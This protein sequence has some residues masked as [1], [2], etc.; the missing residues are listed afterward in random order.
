MH[1]HTDRE[2]CLLITAQILGMIQVKPPNKIQVKS[3]FFNPRGLAT[4]L[5]WTLTSRRSPTQFRDHI[6]VYC[7]LKYSHGFMLPREICLYYPM[8]MNNANVNC[9]VCA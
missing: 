1:A 6:R 4:S 3:P 8:T 7:Q 9:S 2:G 5:I